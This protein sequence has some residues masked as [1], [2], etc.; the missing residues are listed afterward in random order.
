ME[1]GLF[2]FPGRRAA[3]GTLSA[4]TQPIIGL[5][6]HKESGKDTLAS[7]LIKD[8]GYTRLAFA[9]DLKALAYDLNPWIETD[10]D[11]FWRLATLV[12]MSSWDEAKKEFEVRRFLQDLGVSL[13]E[14]DPNFWVDRVARRLEIENGPIVITDVRFLNEVDLVNGYSGALARIVREEADTAA[15]HDSHV[16]EHELDMVWA[17]YTIDNNGTLESLRSAAAGLAAAAVAHAASRV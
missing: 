12:D 6:G 11:G 7:F 1:R 14:R 8:H 3:R 9:D 16:S 15:L 2:V 10:H 5:L 13:R 17:D 4:M